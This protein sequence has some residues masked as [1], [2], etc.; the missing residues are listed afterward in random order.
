MPPDAASITLHACAVAWEGRAL[1]F[2]GPSGS[3]KS[4]MALELMAIGCRLV[5]DDQVILTP[6]D[7]VLVATAPDALHGMIEARGIGL[8]AV[9]PVSGPATV[10]AEVDLSRRE[11]DRL[12]PHR[13]ILRA[14]V[15]L[16]LLWRPQ[17]PN[18]AP[19][20]LQFLKSGRKH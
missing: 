3:G 1:L 11:P 16:P 18:P 2:T 10:V 13:E 6:E 15:T 5:A 4:Q 17:M 12:P 8:L 20:L 9:D 14:G 7:G 19:S